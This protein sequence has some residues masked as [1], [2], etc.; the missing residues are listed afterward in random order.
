MWLLASLRGAA[1]IEVE[2]TDQ[3]ARVI[4]PYLAAVA[5]QGIQVEISAPL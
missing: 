4:A 5:K 2:V 1:S 3:V